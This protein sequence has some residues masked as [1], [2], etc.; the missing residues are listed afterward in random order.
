LQGRA[1]KF[2]DNVLNDGQI[3][4]L[5]MLRSGIYDPAK[6]AAHC[7]AGIDPEFPKKAK[8]GDIIVAGRNFGKGQNHITGPLG[9]K[10]LG[11]GVVTES[12]TRPFFR[13][14][15]VAGL[16]MLPFVRGITEFVNDGD[17][18]VVDF[19]QGTIE[20]AGTGATL[21]TDPL[22]DLVLE[23]LEAGGERE[24]LARNF[25]EAASPS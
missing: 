12:M 16:L 23:F 10:G 19:R 3:T 15:V 24:W 1:W 25:G 13:Q 14:S 21:R 8:P 22:P 6:L 20:N 4:T 2:G 7:M 18:L 5:E 11:L 9:I 17:M